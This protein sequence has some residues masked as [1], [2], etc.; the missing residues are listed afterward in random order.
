MTAM[1]PID[2][3]HSESN[4]QSTH[5][6]ESSE[7]GDGRSSLVSFVNPIQAR[8]VRRGCVRSRLEL[9]S[10]CVCV[11][12]CVRYTK[13]QRSSTQILLS[14]RQRSKHAIQSLLRKRKLADFD[15]AV[16]ESQAV[17]KRLEEE[18]G[19]QFTRCTSTRVQI[20]TQ[21]A[22]LGASKSGFFCRILSLWTGVACRPSSSAQHRLPR[23]Q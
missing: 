12:V 13:A 1:T 21:K 17:A 4:V 19:T 16:P 7:P 14:S 20:L 6:F 3:H 22:L 9:V 2:R 23:I 18:L 15:T 5:R 11:C 10:V 8:G